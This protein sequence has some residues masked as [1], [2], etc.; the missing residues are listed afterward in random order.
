MRSNTISAPGATTGGGIATA[1]MTIS[2]WRRG[3]RTSCAIAGTTWCW[4]APR[5]ASTFAPSAS[6]RSAGC[7]GS[8]R[9]CKS[10]DDPAPAGPPAEQEEQSHERRDQGQCQGV[11]GSCHRN[12][13]GDIPPRLS[14]RGGKDIGFFSYLRTLGAERIDPYLDRW[15]PK[16]T[17]A[18]EEY[19]EDVEWCTEEYLDQYW[20]DARAVWRCLCAGV[21][22][23][24]SNL[25]RATL[26][27]VALIIQR[28]HPPGPDKPLGPE[29][30]ERG[31]DGEE[32]RPPA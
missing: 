13:Q 10:H 18:W 23:N 24:D 14:K 27:H 12:G 15:L 8:P 2:W 4:P 22:L 26:T 16:A 17:A 28:G 5:S 9:L 3:A 7:C 11:A 31:L 32:R 30:P 1:S 6:E 25:A 29:L 21:E 19:G 20:K